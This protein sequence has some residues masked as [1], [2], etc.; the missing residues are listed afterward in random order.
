MVIKIL[1]KHH[2]PIIVW[3]PLNRITLSFLLKR[4]DNEGGTFP[5]EKVRDFIKLYQK[6]KRT[7]HRLVLADIKSADGTTVK[8]IM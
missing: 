4:I 7:F 1:T 6:S 3:I 8:V 5:K 2:L